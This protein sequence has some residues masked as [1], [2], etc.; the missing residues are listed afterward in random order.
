M[1]VRRPAARRP[2]ARGP[3]D[4]PPPRIMV[5]RCPEL[6]WPEELS[7]ARRD[8][9]RSAPDS[10]PPG[11]PGPPA[12]SAD[13]GAARLFEQVIAVVTG[14]CPKVEVVE[15]GVCAFGARG[16]ARYFGGETALAA[17]I[18]AAAA[19]LGVESRAGAAE[20]LF[21]ALL[22]AR[23][24]RPDA[25]RPDAASPGAASP[26]QAAGTVGSST[27]ILVIP[28]GETARFL[29]AQPVSVLAD[30][31][32][33]GLL[34][35]LGLGTLGDFAALPAHD[36][37]SRFGDAGECAHRLARGL[38]SR[39]LAACPPPA[40]LSVVQEFDPPEPQA[41]PV[42]FAAKTLAEQ[43]HAGLAAR[44][45][46]CV[47]VQVRATWADGR[48]SSRLWR[49][50][51]LLSAAGV[52]DRV[53]WQLDGWRPEADAGQ[54]PEGGVAA[55]RLAPDLLVRAAGQQLALWGETVVSDRVARAAM[56]VQAMLGHEAVL[57]PVIGG[58]R[59]FA[60]QVTPIPFG[61]KTEPRLAADRPW[62]G[63]VIGPAPG[64]VYPIAREAEVRD[65]DGE[66]VT[67]NGRCVV[68]AAPARLAVPGEPPRRVTGWVGPW[69]LSERW[70]DPAAARRRARFQLATD[71]GRAWLAVVQDGRWLIEAAY[72]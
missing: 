22:A 66:I 60:G 14:F 26:A 46:T 47:R 8:S 69:P 43:L 6:C 71:D 28:P 72:C 33:A 45:L 64:V 42:V 55:L 32:L 31:E 62:P 68:S 10:R 65:D 50:D 7:Q 44:G 18:I 1:N 27:A 40:D 38:D 16:P 53:R 12:G 2:D 52:A 61:E 5:L 63:R 4:L 24:S 41:E 17:K 58:G 21:A 20:G 36:V 23:A 54:Y 29:A 13:H 57:R 35:R 37:A 67:V 48:E 70:W 3:A 49:H 34:K 19:D 15:P 56:R 51:G 11:G 9:G 39:P 30:Q 25:A 59:D